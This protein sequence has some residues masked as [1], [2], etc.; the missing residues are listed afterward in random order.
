MISISVNDHA[1]P[2]LR[3]F[4]ATVKNPMPGLMVAGRAVVNLLRQ[5]YRD[6]DRNQPNKLGGTRTHFWLQIGRSVH[7]PKQTGASEVTVQ[8]SDPRFPQKVY[9]GVISVKNKPWL[10]IPMRSEAYGRAASVLENALGIR[11]F[12]YGNTLSAKQDGHIIAYYALC[13]KTRPQKKDPTA[14]PPEAQMGQAAAKAM[15]A[16]MERMKARAG[17]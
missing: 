9:G 8:I 14:F 11:L 7:S 1:S 10:T 3:Q 12:R 6:K 16:Y 2:A 4:A 13:K 17:S 5:H 15:E